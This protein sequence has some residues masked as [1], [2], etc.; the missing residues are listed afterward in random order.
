MTE[1][2]EYIEVTQLCGGVSAHMGRKEEIEAYNKW[3]TL[4]DRAGRALL[5]VHQPEKAPVPEFDDLDL[6]L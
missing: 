4:Q 2:I 3:K 5:K 1:V 6:D